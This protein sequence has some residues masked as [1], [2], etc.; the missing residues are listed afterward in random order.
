MM[1][2][3]AENISG[4]IQLAMAP[5]FLLVAIGAVL[6]LF[7]GRLARVVDRSRVLKTAYADTEGKEHD[8]V[9]QELRGLS[10]RMKIVNSAI[11]MGVC[12]AIT[13]GLCIV[14]LFTMALFQIN[15]SIVIAAGFILAMGFMIT[16]LLYFLVEVRLA[17]SNVAVET[18]YL[19]LD[20]R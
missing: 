12:G 18:H 17:S 10:R 13:I 7:A 1:H 11:L 20:K 8:R 3:G 16:G 19:E 14:S 4:L 15:L 6:Q 2:I 9:V 5:A